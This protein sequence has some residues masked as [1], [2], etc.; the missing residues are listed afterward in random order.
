MAGHGAGL[1]GGD[2]CY[3]NSCW[4]VSRISAPMPQNIRMMT[5]AAMT[6]TQIQ[7]QIEATMGDILPPGWLFDSVFWPEISQKTLSKT[8]ILKNF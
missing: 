6:L 4:N 3:A 5:G 2:D 7:A 8:D 1:G